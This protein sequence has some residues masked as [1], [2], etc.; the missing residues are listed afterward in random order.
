M[1]RGSVVAHAAG[2]EVVACPC[3]RGMQNVGIGAQGAVRRAAGPALEVAVQQLRKPVPELSVTLV[4]GGDLARFVA[5][6]V[7]EPPRD[8][9]ASL[10]G[11]AE[12]QVQGVVAYL[13]RIHANVLAAVREAARCC[14]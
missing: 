6:T 13:G 7:T 14:L 10:Q 11:S 2:C 5:M 9:W 1:L 4:S 12:E 3:I 8:L